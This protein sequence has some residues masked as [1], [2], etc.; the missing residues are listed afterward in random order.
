[1][2]GEEV[3]R[4]YAQAVVRVARDGD[5]IEPVGRELLLFSRLYAENE[6]MR[7]LLECPRVGDPA[8]K[9]LVKDVGDALGLGDLTIH[10]IMLLVDKR[11]IRFIHQISTEYAKIADR[12]AHR[13][14]ALIKSAIPLSETQRDRLKG[15][16]ERITGT[17]V[18]LRVVKDED[19]I[20]GVVVKVGDKLFDGS[21][22]GELM[23]IG[24]KLMEGRD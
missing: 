13:Q 4:I 3:G 19:I 9:K 10:F 17:S 5:L 22:Q 7:R 11:R 23:K 15:I 24:K 12:E 6:G 8:K 1:M 21:L 14:T 18:K 2:I 16:I 20:G